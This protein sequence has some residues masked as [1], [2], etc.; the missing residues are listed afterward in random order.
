MCYVK[1]SAGMLWGRGAQVWEPRVRPEG[2]AKVW[3]NVLE[4]KG[5]VVLVGRIGG[6]VCRRG[7]RERLGRDCGIMVR[8]LGRRDGMMERWSGVASMLDRLW[9]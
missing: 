8:S 2:R 7:G 6:Y 5:V 3:P 1:G 4:C 9:G